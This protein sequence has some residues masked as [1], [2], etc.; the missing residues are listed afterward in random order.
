MLV[1]AL[2]GALGRDRPPRPPPVPDDVKSVGVQTPADV[3][4]NPG[5]DSGTDGGA[6]IPRGVCPACRRA[7][8]N[9]R[10]CGECQRIC[11][12]GGSSGGGDDD[13]D[14]VRPSRTLARCLRRSKSRCLFRTWRRRVL[15]R[16][17]NAA[18]SRKRRN[19]ARERSFARGGR[20]GARSAPRNTRTPR[21]RPFTDAERSNRRWPRGASSPGAFATS[22]TALAPNTR[23]R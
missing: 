6:T 9:W 7:P 11:A 17:R 18:T 1:D 22:P 8:A 23:R 4:Q 21:R 5:G 16:A 20:R 14:D 19:T 12:D 3:P 15:A 13:D 10:S 2:R